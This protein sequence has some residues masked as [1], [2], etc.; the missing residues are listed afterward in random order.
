MFLNPKALLDLH[1]WLFLVFERSCGF[2]G[3][4][5]ENVASHH[6]DDSLYGVRLDS[7]HLDLINHFDDR[8]NRYR[9]IAQYSQPL[10][11]YVVRRLGV[12]DRNEARDIVNEFFLQRV[13]QDK[14]RPSIVQRYCARRALDSTMR[15]RPYLLRSLRN[16]YLDAKSRRVLETCSIGSDVAAPEVKLPDDMQ[17]EIE[18]ANNLIGCAIESFQLECNLVNPQLWTAFYCRC[19]IPVIGPGRQMT[20]MELAGE[21]GVDD[22]EKGS[23]MSITAQRKFNRILRE[24]IDPFVKPAADESQDKAVELELQELRDVMIRSGRL[25]I[26]LPFL[27]ATVVPSQLAPVF[28]ISEDPEDLWQT[29]DRKLLWQQLQR[30]PIAVLLAECGE[31]VSL[32]KDLMTAIA[33]AGSKQLRDLWTAESPSLEL[34]T[35]VKESVKQL[36]QLPRIHPSAGQGQDYV[37]PHRVLPLEMQFAVY[38]LCISAAQVRH[39]TSLTHDSHLITCKRLMHASRLPWLDDSSRKLLVRTA[40]TYRT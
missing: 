5:S 3:A 34:L 38:M 11:A 17:F 8:A 32:P 1:Q 27:D 10:V 29:E 6:T 36:S 16:F 24:L 9:F 25:Q 22:V 28:S 39:K 13:L 14:D 33:N 4:E 40:N 12:R 21:L 37:T 7:T 35:A 15:F 19:L 23:R 20:L 26:E 31:L 2:R 30:K 18:W